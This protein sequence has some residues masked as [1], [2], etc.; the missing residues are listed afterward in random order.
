MR[1][2]ISHGRMVDMRTNARL[3]L[4]ILDE[5][6]NSEAIE[7]VIQRGVVVDRAALLNQ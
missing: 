3:C 4:T 7:T 2:T 1:V 6:R 5:I